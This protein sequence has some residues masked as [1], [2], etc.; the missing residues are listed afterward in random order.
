MGGFEAGH[1]IVAGKVGRFYAKVAEAIHDGVF[2]RGGDAD[3]AHAL[4]VAVAAD[5]EEA[6][7]FAADHAAQEGEV[8]DPVDVGGAV[9]VVGDA[10]GPG[11]DGAAGGGEEVVHLLE[12]S[13][14]LRVGSCEWGGRSC[15][16]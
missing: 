1:G 2:E 15:E 13:C 7:A 4:D 10:H 6:G 14:E 8:D 5:G 16:L 12:F 3:G 9:L 11:E